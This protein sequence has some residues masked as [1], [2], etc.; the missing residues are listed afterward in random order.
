LLISRPKNNLFWNKKNKRKFIEIKKHITIFGKGGI[1]I[2]NNDCDHIIEA[3]PHHSMLKKK[4]VE[5][6]LIFLL[7]TFQSYQNSHFNFDKFG[8]MIY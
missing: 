4:E 1:K 6:L 2:T 5:N 8:N 3:I 7:R